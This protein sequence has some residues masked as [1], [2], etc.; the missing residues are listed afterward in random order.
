MYLVL[1][2]LE[3]FVVARA[4]ALPQEIDNDNLLNQ[5]QLSQD[6]PYQDQ[7]VAGYPTDTVPAQDVSTSDDSGIQNYVG[8]LPDNLDISSTTTKVTSSADNLRGLNEL[9]AVSN[10]IRDSFDGQNSL[11]RIPAKPQ[12][13]F[14]GT[15]DLD[16]SALGTFSDAA[17]P[18]C[19]DAE[20]SEIPAEDLNNLIS[21][22]E[23]ADPDC[24]PDRWPTCCEKKLQKDGTVQRCLHYCTIYFSSF[25]CEPSISQKTH[26]FRISKNRVDF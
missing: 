6:Q 19:D 11:D 16:A 12:E 25:R 26:L 24:G 17:L 20:K 10:P 18:Y 8:F 23:N 15:S 7:V 14:A 5:D 21:R 2:V 4:T 13:N 22:G 9:A 1:F 3:A